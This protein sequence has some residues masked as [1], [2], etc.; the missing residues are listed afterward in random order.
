MKGALEFNLRQ[1]LNIK[2]LCLMSNS[3]ALD[4]IFNEHIYQCVFF[5]KFSPNWLLIFIL[6]WERKNQCWGVLTLLW[7]PPKSSFHIS[8]SQPGYWIS[9][10]FFSHPRL[11][12]T[13]KPKVNKNLMKMSNKTLWF[14]F[15]CFEKIQK[16]SSFLKANKWNLTYLNFQ[17][18]C[19]LSCQL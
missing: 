4:W 16:Y 6:T 14:A 12:D 7:E 2:W 11:G 3:N 17:H 18:R 19:C 15:F 9:F 5:V 8:F 10:F 1:P 13:L